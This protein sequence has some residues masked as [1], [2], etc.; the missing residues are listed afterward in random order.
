[1]ERLKQFKFGC[2]SRQNADSSVYHPSLTASVNFASKDLVSS[3]WPQ[4]AQRRHDLTTMTATTTAT[5]TTA[6]SQQIV[7]DSTTPATARLS[8]IGSTAYPRRNKKHKPV[9][10]SVLSVVILCISSYHQRQ[11]YVVIIRGKATSCK[12]AMESTLTSAH[13]DV[14]WHT[15]GLSSY[16]NIRLYGVYWTS[17]VFLIVL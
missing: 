1:L 8:H 2:V 4:A 12:M 11:S 5:V 16:H 7:N 6:Q 14:S 9:D 13:C 10:C 17:W 15:K 3:M